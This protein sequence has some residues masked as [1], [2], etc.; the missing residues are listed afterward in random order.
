MATCE[1]LIENSR[2][3]I[4]GQT[5]SLVDL[6]VDFYNGGQLAD[7]YQIQR[8]EIYRCS[9]S[10][11]NLEAVIPFTDPTN[12]V[13]PS[14]ACQETM[15][16]APGDCGTEPSTDSIPIPGK[17]HLPFLVPSDFKAPDVYI[18]V[19][20]FYPRN[21]CLG[22]TYP[23]ACDPSDLTS[24]LNSDLLCDPTDPQFEDQLVTCCHRFWVYPEA[25]LCNDGLQTVNF[26]FEPLNVRFNSPE[27]RP[28]EVGLIPLPVYSYNKNLVDP[29]IP[30]LQASITVG[31][32][33]CDI[34]VQDA[35][36]ELGLRQGPYRS[37]P[38]VVKW[39]LDTSTFIRGSYWY[40][41]KL[42][43]PDGT[44]RVSQK[45]WFEIR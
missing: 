25:W 36:M 8:V 28:L 27:I 15:P 14:P 30:F 9:V 18:D 22:D 1:C 16:V 34:L 41:I 7:P 21:P 23:D 45:F 3:R 37:N 20:Y 4:S 40:Q 11:E 10:P 17:Y 29:L 6:N 13:Y 42:T 44:T 39:N 32:Q 5:G 38:W 24:G 2:P 19:W 35:P 43:L 33:F 26:G 12:S 31:T